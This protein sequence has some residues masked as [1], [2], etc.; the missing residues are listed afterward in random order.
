[1]SKAQFSALYVS[2]PR[3]PS[4]GGSS[5]EL[6]DE[7][8]PAE[9]RLPGALWQ[10]FPVQLRPPLRHK[11]GVQRRHRRDA[12]HPQEVPPGGRVTT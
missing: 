10:P 8:R 1:M 6:S 9:Q 7:E 11:D 4:C 5:S 2:L 12:Q 3:A